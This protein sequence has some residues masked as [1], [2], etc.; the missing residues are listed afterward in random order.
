[1]PFLHPMKPTLIPNTDTYIW[2]SHIHRIPKTICELGLESKKY[3]IRMVQ[4]VDSTTPTYLKGEERKKFV[5]RRWQEISKDLPR[6]ALTDSII[7]VASAA[8]IIYIML[9][10][11]GKL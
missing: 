5:E 10:I 6:D 3:F 2:G 4:R 7:I 1:M 8:T 11:N 9:R